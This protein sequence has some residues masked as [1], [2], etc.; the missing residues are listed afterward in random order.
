M[1]LHAVVLDE[2][3]PSVLGPPTTLE[4]PPQMST[5]SDETAVVS[6]GVTGGHQPRSPALPE[7]QDRSGESL[8]DC[9]TESKTSPVPVL[10][11]C[12]RR[13]RSVDRFDLYR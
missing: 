9:T 8:T 1:P 7:L 12:S 11:Q 6:P 5:A 3:L 10:R 13:G 2:G 4:S